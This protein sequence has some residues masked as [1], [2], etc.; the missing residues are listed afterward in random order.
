MIILELSDSSGIINPSSESFNQA[1]KIYFT[2]R[3]QQ[4]KEWALSRKDAEKKM[5][6]IKL[7][8]SSNS[9]STSQPKI[10]FVNEEIKAVVLSY[11]RSQ[12]NLLKEIKFKL[13]ESES[14]PVFIPEKLWPKYKIYT[15]I[16]TNAYVPS[17]NGDYFNAFKNLSKLWNKDTLLTKFSFYESAKDSL[18]DFADKI[19]SVSNRQFTKQLENFKA[20]ITDQNLS[21]LFELK[22]SIFESL[23]Y[24]DTFL[25]SIKNEVDAVSRSINIENQKQFILKN[26]DKSK[27]LFRKKKMSIF[28][29]KTYADYQLKLFTEALSKIITSINKIKQITGFDSIHTEHL[30]NFPAL[31]K[32]LS[33]MGWSNDFHSVCKLLNE[34]IIK[35]QYIFNDTIINTFSQ[36]KLNEPQPYYALFRAFNALV[37]KDKRLF[38]ELV[39][40]CMFAISD[41]DL[42]SSLDLYIALVNSETISNDEY[43][44]LIQKGYNSQTSGSLQEAKL[45]YEKAEK[46]SN[47]GEIL[48]FLIAETNLKLGD[49]YS[50]EIYFKRANLI[51]PKFILPK[52]YQ[53]E[54]LIEDKDYETALTLVNEALINNP[55]WYFY[56]KK[57]VLLGL[58]GKY[59]DAKSL[60]INNCLPLNPL[61]YEQYLFL[62]DVFNALS[63]T[64]SAREYYMKAGNIKPNDSAYKNKM[65]ILKQNQEIKPI[66]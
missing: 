14:D 27:S 54:F 2:A 66:K 25:I 29:E 30:K 58:T 4:E 5:A 23:L 36:N 64:K 28:E 53:I 51:N 3:P 19:I 32:E 55:I 20:N 7:L 8:Q 63:D 37:K 40:Q 44:E 1:E 13:E 15:E 48:F 26:L 46:L 9:I 6:E 31:N 42:L 41:K 10:L 60:L 56:Y 12:I 17:I 65:E 57:A 62:G 49:R 24:V 38:V 39:N 33:E 11:P 34:N 35:N 52:L 59:N 50:A 47:T 16:I 18:A 45:S 21:Q 43:W 61:N 22:D